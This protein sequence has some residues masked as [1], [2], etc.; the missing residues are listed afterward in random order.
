MRV[1]RKLLDCR[2]RQPD[3][4]RC[5]SPRL[6]LGR[7]RHPAVASASPGARCRHATHATH[8]KGCRPGRPDASHPLLVARGLVAVGQGQPLRTWDA[9]GSRSRAGRASSVGS[10][11][12]T[13]NGGVYTWVL[14]KGG[15]APASTAEH[16]RP[17]G[18]TR[19]TGP[20]DPGFRGGRQTVR[21]GR[22]AG[23]MMK[24]Q[25][26]DGVAITAI[27]GIAGI[28][29]A[30][31]AMWSVSAPRARRGRTGCSA[32]APCRRPKDVRSTPDHVQT[33][34][35]SWSGAPRPVLA[36]PRSATCCRQAVETRRGP[37]PWRL[38]KRLGWPR[39][40]IR[41]LRAKCNSLA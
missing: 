30:A 25:A 7:G 28:A 6:P 15:P 39:A 35:C 18:T 16:A 3:A 17:L 23:S 12:H 1:V 4:F 29:M 2:E 40:P 37:I 21:D 34:A 9:T 8:G 26:G 19:P 33:A 13:V 41:I 38:T 14:G 11:R 31:S 36:R 10:G 27:A 22:L 5:V 24:S 32:V 20:A